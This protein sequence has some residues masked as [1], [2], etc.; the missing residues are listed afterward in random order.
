[1]TRETITH[2]CGKFALILLILFAGTVLSLRPAIAGSLEEYPD[3]SPTPPIHLEDLSGK[4]HS[5]QEYQGNVVLVNFWA[6]WCPPCLLEMPGMQ[7]L[8]EQMTGKPFAILAVNAGESRATAWKFLNLVKADFTVLLDSEKT[9][10]EEWQVQI[11]PTSYLI[12]TTGRIR[13][14]AFGAL[15]WDAPDVH[16]VI[17]EMVSGTLIKSDFT[18]F[19]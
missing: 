17:E 11:Y 13:Y 3:I 6:S 8:K 9:V 4:T 1:M 15:D 19:Q 18:D 12:D 2:P 14:V 5:L 10:A 7:R 16:R